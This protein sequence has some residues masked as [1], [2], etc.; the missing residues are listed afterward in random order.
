MTLVASTSCLICE[1]IS[2]S[3]LRIR[4]FAIYYEFVFLQVKKDMNISGR[5][6]LR[7]AVQMLNA[8]SRYPCHSEYSSIQ[9]YYAIHVNRAVA[10]W[11]KNVTLTSGLFRRFLGQENKCVDSV[12]PVRGILFALFACQA[13]RLFNGG[14]LTFVM[15]SGLGFNSLC[16]QNIYFEGANPA[17][18]NR[19]SMRVFFPLGIK[20]F[21]KHGTR[22][23]ENGEN[24]EKTE[25]ER[26]VFRKNRAG[27]E[28]SVPRK[29]E[30]F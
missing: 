29:G 11:E 28:F 4:I 18:K 21:R 25:K 3:V 20:P 6:V 5:T 23:K 27:T 16:P 17:G 8:I 10:I 22:S 12:P 13:S 19:R 2:F 26:A 15:P 9:R 30:S 14:I 7:F 1:R 24:G